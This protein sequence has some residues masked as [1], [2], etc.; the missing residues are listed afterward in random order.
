MLGP[1]TELLAEIRNLHVNRTLVRRT[2]QNTS[3]MGH[4]P[5]QEVEL[6]GGQLQRLAVQLRQAVRLV[7]Q[8][9]VEVYALRLGESNGLV[10]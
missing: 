3:A 5:H 4:E 1:R 7:E 8:E 2:G 9:S 10:T 6:A